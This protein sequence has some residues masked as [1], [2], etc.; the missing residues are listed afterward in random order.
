MLTLQGLRDFGA[1]VDTGLTRC[2]NSEAFYLKMVR[3]MI[4]TTSLS[5]LKDALVARDL[6]KAFE[7]CHGMKGVAGNLSLTPVYLTVNEMTELLRSRTD[8]DYGP[9]MERLETALKQLKQL[10]E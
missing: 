6:A 1:D 9:Y 10:A 7:L 8:T 3:K 2:M 5:E 4:D